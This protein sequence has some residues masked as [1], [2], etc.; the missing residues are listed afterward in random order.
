[1]AYDIPAR[2]IYFWLT[3]M[4]VLLLWLLFSQSAAAQQETLTLAEAVVSDQVQVEIEG[5]NIA[6][7]QPMLLFR[8]TNETERPLIL[9]LEQG[10]QLH[11]SNPNYADIILSQT[12]TI[13]LPPGETISRTA[14]AYSLDV[15]LAFPIPDITFAPETLS[16]NEELLALLQQIHNSEAETTLAAQLAVWMQLAGTSDFDAFVA[17]FD[18]N[19]DLQSQR[20][21]TLQLLGASAGLGGI[22][23]TVVLPIILL[24]LLP[25]LA[26]LLPR[27]L[28]KQFA[29]YRLI[30]HL[31]TGV[32]YHIQQAQ[33]RGTPQLIAI[34]QPVDDVTEARCLREIEIRECIAPHAP[35]IVPMQASGY[36]GNDKNSRP[37]PYFVETYIDGADLSKVLTERPKLGTTIAL[38]IV[39]QL[40]EALRHLHQ[41]VGIIHREIKPSNILVDKQGQ[42]WLTDFAAA[43]MPEQSEFNQVKRGENSDVQ[44]NAPEYVQRKQSLFYANG[45]PPQ[46]DPLIQNQQ[47]DIFSLGVLLYQLGTGRSPFVPQQ[48]NGRLFYAPT[49]R[50]DAFMEL[51]PRLALAIQQCLDGDPTNRFATVTALQHALGLPLPADVTSRAQAELGRLVQDVMP[52]VKS[53]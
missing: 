13:T 45:K 14:Y 2:K 9:T 15:D 32:K 33:Q 41:Q 25:L 40:I 35:H 22:I 51:E 38:E 37:R 8:V 28:R 18:T 21:L 42:V 43:T 50:P 4:G 23:L 36:F 1:M 26:L 7:I 49:L 39:A 34:K 24:I 31:A 17:R 46:L 3:T 30:T 20:R 6:Y 12:E 48:Q 19:V 47:V 5:R 53:S 29:G 52:S 10:Q 44:W 16:H 27:H 11:S